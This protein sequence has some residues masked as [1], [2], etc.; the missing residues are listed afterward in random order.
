MLPDLYAS[1]GGVTVSFFEWV[2][3][4]QEDDTLILVI[5]DSLAQRNC[6]TLAKI[7]GSDLSNRCWQSVAIKAFEANSRG[8]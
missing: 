1:A 3:Y 8:N 6:E 2:S 7:A 4:I 5:L